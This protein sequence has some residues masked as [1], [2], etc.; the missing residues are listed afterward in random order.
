MPLNHAA[1]AQNQQIQPDSLEDLH[2]RGFSYADIAKKLSL[3]ESTVAWRV[4]RYRAVVGLAN[5]HRAIYDWG[6]VAAFQLAGHSRLEC[7]ERFG[8]SEATW[9]FAM[10]KGKVLNASSPLVMLARILRRKRKD[11]RRTLRNLILR[12]GAIPYVCYR[13]HTGP[14][15]NG[16][17]LTL[18]LDHKNGV[19]NDHSPENLRFV[20]PNCDSQQDTYGGKNRTRV[21]PVR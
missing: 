7:M 12:T 16:L 18:N 17:P 13:C 21:K 9:F 1:S 5:R 15:W 14:E 2:R 20:C 6:A 10:K 11:D 8:M 3:P 4:R 19:N